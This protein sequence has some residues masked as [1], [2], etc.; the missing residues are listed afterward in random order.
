MA[1]FINALMACAS[2]SKKLEKNLQ[3]IGEIKISFFLFLG[4]L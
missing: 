4:R 3:L 2:E 1:R